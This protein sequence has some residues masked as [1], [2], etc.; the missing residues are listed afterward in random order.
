ML[1]MIV[2]VVVMICFNTRDVFKKYALQEVNDFW[3]KEITQPGSMD[4]MQIVVSL[5]K[6]K[7]IKFFHSFFFAF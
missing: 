1:V 7:N 5:H 3:Q 6:K 4:N 2:L